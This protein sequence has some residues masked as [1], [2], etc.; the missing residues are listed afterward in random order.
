M[1]PDPYKQKNS[2]KY[3]KPASKPQVQVLAQ[4]KPLEQDV[5]EQLERDF[6]SLLDTQEDAHQFQFTHEKA[7]QDHTVADSMYSNLFVLQ[8][9]ELRQKVGD[10]VCDWQRV[11]SVSTLE[12]LPFDW[13]VEAETPL[14]E[15]V[16]EKKQE[17]IDE[18]LDDIL[19]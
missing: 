2:R 8:L 5:D 6:Q 9:E 17:T 7:T 3:H 4:P 10:G 1:R 19:N 14:V 13:I 11:A 12:Y 18:W 15:I 16:H